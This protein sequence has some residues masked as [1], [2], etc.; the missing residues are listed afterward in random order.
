MSTIAVVHSLEEKLLARII[1]AAPG[2]TV[3]GGQ[4][5]MK[6]M[7]ILSEAEIIFGWNS[8]VKEAALLPD[9]KLKWVQNWGAGVERLPLAELDGRGIQ[10][11]NA[12]GVHPNPISETI[13]AMLL[14]FTR[15][16]HLSVRNQQMRQWARHGDMRELHGSTIGIL[17][18]GAIGMETAKVAKAFNMT[19]LGVRR[20]GRPEANVDRMH[21]M[22]ELPEVLRQCDYVVNCLPH[23]AETEHLIGRE[24]FDA[25]KPSA[26][27]INIGRG[28][29]TDTEALLD[30]LK[31]GKI[32]GAGLD[33]FEQEP[34][35]PEHP[36]WSMANV[37]ITPHN[38]GSTPQYMNRLIDIFTANLKQYVQG[39]P[40]PLNIVKPEAGY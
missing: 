11:T 19:V 14:A 9:S 36:L 29:T 17:G 31:S 3:I 1:D 6:D 32:A 38:A 13:F 23:T 34:L 7:A 4:A 25:M 40:L 26:Y 22:K 35:P 28:M 5:S 8:A 39:Q 37:I 15:E 2:W 20:S 27:Y 18:V 21:E 10:V 12:T 24:A 33:V 30:A 16:L